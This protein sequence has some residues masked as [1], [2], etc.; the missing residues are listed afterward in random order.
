MGGYSIFANGREVQLSIEQWRQEHVHRRPHSSL[1]YTVFA[2]QA[3][4]TL[5]LV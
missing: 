3:R 2:D 1:G 4:L 5:D